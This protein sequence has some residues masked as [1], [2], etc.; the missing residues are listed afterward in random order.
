MWSQ[1]PHG[2][3]VSLSQPEPGYCLT[4]A[5]EPARPPGE[6]AKAVPR[7]MVTV[8]YKYTGPRVPRRVTFWLCSSCLLK[9]DDPRDGLTG[10]FQGAQ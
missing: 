6:P 10:P 4:T 9:C 8:L 2:P 5:S 1:G 7:Q 3:V